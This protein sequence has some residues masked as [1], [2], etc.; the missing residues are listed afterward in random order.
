MSAT[1]E[2]M[3]DSG[4]SKRTTTITLISTI[5]IDAP[6]PP[7]TQFYKD[8]STTYSAF[9]KPLHIHGIIPGLQPTPP[10]NSRSPFQPHT[11]STATPNSPKPAHPD[12]PTSSKYPRPSPPGFLYPEPI[13]PPSASTAHNTHTMQHTSGN[14]Y[15]PNILPQADYDL[16]YLSPGLKVL[17]LVTLATITLAGCWTILVLGINFPPGEWG[18]WNIK[19]KVKE[20]RPLD[21]ASRYACSDGVVLACVRGPGNKV[22]RCGR[23]NGYAGHE[24]ECGI[25]LQQNPQHRFPHSGRS[26]V[27]GRGGGN[28][29]TF[30]AHRRTCSSPS[31]APILNIS[32]TPIPTPTTLPSTTSSPQN[33][34][35]VPPQNAL[36]QPGAHIAAPRTHTR[37]SGEWIAERTAFFSSHTSLP[38]HNGQQNTYSKSSSPTSHHYSSSASGSSSRDISD[39]EA[40]E[41]GTAP[42]T[43]YKCAS[44]SS[45]SDSDGEQGM[46]RR[47]LRWLDQGLGMVDGVVGRVAGG[48]ARWTDDEGVAEEGLLVKLGGGKRKVE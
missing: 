13:V 1:P 40:L 16:A 39:A 30:T 36:L 11:L 25:E 41:A 7:P 46:L 17:L 27:L 32:A 2:S 10:K 31:A 35:L 45:S 24:G 12:P 9:S 43:G 3:A 34:F 14:P 6:N 21:K 29:N 23:E 5:T 18:I 8:P 28:D 19:G 20:M 44:L 22:Q 37:T 42:L 33:P 4:I 15:H 38:L 26:E 47:S 48:L